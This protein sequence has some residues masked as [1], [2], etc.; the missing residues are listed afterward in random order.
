MKKCISILVLLIIMCMPTL[1]GSKNKVLK[2][3]DVALTEAAK[4]DCRRYCGDTIDRV[5][6]YDNFTYD[7]V[8]KIYSVRI[9]LLEE[10]CETDLIDKETLRNE[11]LEHLSRQEMLPFLGAMH[12]VGGS[13]VYEYVGNITKHSFSIHIQ[14]VDINRIYDPF[15]LN[16][17][18]KSS[19]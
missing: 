10:F 4:E 2:Q 12:T 8:E 5:G 1:A 11:L 13:I 16:K 9:I 17:G 19:K 6:Y 18:G 14:W 3:Y 15:R 7:S